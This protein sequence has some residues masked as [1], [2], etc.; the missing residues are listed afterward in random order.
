MKKKSTP[1]YMSPY[2]AD[3]T[4]KVCSLN[5]DNINGEDCW[6]L[7]DGYTVTVTA[8]KPGE[9]PTGQ[10]SLPRAQFAKLARWFF[11]EQKLRQR[12][13]NNGEAPRG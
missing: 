6:I 8:Q 7:T 5:R 2:R 4:D 13:A 9:G 1:K 12:R 3:T 10:V 11:T